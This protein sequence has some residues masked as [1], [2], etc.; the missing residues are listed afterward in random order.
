MPITVTVPTVGS[1]GA[2]AYALRRPGYCRNHRV[3]TTC[4]RIRIRVWPA[5]R[6]CTL[7]LLIGRKD[8]NGVKTKLEQLRVQAIQALVISGYCVAAAGAFV[9]AA[10]LAAAAIDPIT[11]VWDKTI[12]A[13]NAAKLEQLANHCWY[14]SMSG[15]APM[16]R[17]CFSADAQA[18]I[19]RRAKRFIDARPK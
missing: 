13:H 10:L 18:A 14:L 16:P 3:R 17:E 5:R 6:T 2:S 8:G 15:A 12:G 4:R 7:G 1:P 19:E 9:L 11:T